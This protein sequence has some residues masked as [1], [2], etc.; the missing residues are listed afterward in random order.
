MNKNVWVT[1][2]ITTPRGR[3]YAPVVLTK[4]GKIKADYVLVKGEP[5]HHSEGTYHIEWYV[6]RKR[7]REAVGND[8]GVAATKRQAKQVELSALNH[9]LLVTPETPTNG[10]GDRRTLSTAVANYIEEIKLTKKPKTLSAYTTALDYFAE[11]CTKHY[12]EDIDRKDLLQFSAFLRDDKD[13]SPRSVY[14]KFE[15]IM[16]FLKAQGIRGIVK[17]NDW[18]RYV[19][20][21]PD[22]YEDS[23]LDALFAVCDPAEKLVFEF[24]LMTGMRDQEVMHVYWRDIDFAHRIARVTHKPDRGWTPKAYK[25]REVPIAKTLVDHLREAKPKNAEKSSLI[26]ST[27]SGGLRTHLLD[28]LKDIAKRAGLNEDD[29]YLHKFRATFATKCLWAGVDLRTVQSWLGHNDMES[30]LRY[31]KPARNKTVQDKVDDIFG[32]KKNG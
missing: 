16:T 18:P 22:I 21:E 25:E 1:K 14:N 27:P 3:Q 24:F 15:N 13:Q 23:E 8:A 31:L 26:F 6:G 12:L 4:N 2:R 19:E 30:T 7:I 9:G 10:N 32:G 29:F 17:K 11:S 28:E 5:E 20:E